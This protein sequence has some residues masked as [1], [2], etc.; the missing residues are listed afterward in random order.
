MCVEGLCRPNGTDAF[1]ASWP[2]DA[3]TGDAG[4]DVE[5]R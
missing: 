3:G 4:A 2:G 5:L 1:E